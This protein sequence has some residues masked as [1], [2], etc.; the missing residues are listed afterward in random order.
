MPRAIEILRAALA[1]QWHRNS[2]Y[3]LPHRTDPKKPASNMAMLKFLQQTMDCPRYTVDGFRSSFRTWGEEE[4]DFDYMALEHCLAHIEG[5]ES[6]KAYRRGGMLRKR[7]E[8]LRAWHDHCYPKTK[9]A[10]ASLAA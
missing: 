7:T 9:P 1:M 3:V 5:P 6:S 8:I 2:S 10:L 4:T